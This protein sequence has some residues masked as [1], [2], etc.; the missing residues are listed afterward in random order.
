MLQEGLGS[1]TKQNHVCKRVNT[2]C[3]R[4]PLSTTTPTSTTFSC[5]ACRRTRSR[6]NGVVSSLSSSIAVSSSSSEMGDRKTMTHLA[7]RVWFHC[8]LEALHC[9]L[10]Q[11]CIRGVRPSGPIHTG[12]DAHK[13]SQ[14][15]FVHVMLHRLLL[16]MQ[17]VQDCCYNRICAS[18][19]LLASLPV[20][21]GPQT[22]RQGLQAPFTHSEN[23]DVRINL[24]PNL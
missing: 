19:L 5:C 20:W 3:C 4:S 18:A 23:A 13:W 9:T 24:L 12:R 16:S 11:K 21:M 2:Y 15:P 17:C 14:V 10:E 7:M 8:Q 1:A 6:F 22:K